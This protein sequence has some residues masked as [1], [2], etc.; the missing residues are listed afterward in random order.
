[1]HSQIHVTLCST[2][3]L[4]NKN[5]NKFFLTCVSIDYD[6]TK[7]AKIL[8]VKIKFHR[9][10]FTKDQILQSKLT[11]KPNGFAATAYNRRFHQL[12]CEII[13][14]IFANLCL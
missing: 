3:L 7:F 9:L 6:F 2:Y 13:D 4:N 14:N 5:Y 1:M 8:I 11:A 10:N 12:P